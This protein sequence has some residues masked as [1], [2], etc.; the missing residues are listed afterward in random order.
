MRGFVATS[1]LM[2]SL[3][4]TRQPLSA[5]L[6]AALLLAAALAVYAHLID[7]ELTGADTP[8]AVCLHGAQ[9]DKPATAAAA[10]FFAPVAPSR[11]EPS[12]STTL[13]TSVTVGSSTARG[14]PHGSVSLVS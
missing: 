12:T 13:R 6:L 1:D 7:H 3:R 8:C 9:L 2:R 4:G 5:L 11:L 10:V 14:P